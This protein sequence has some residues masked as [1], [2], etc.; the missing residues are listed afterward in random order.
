MEL[1]IRMLRNFVFGL[2]IGYILGGI[3][4]SCQAHAQT[5]TVREVT[6]QAGRRHN[7]EPRLLRAIIQVESGGNPLA[8]GGVGEVGLM[9][10]NPRSFKHVSF[11]ISTNVETGAAYLAVLRIKCPY[12]SGYTYVVCYNKGLRPRDRN[13]ASTRYYVRV[14]EAYSHGQ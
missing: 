6:E 1:L 7:I 4:H 11:N 10:L 13:P 9:Q 8:V 12:K 2:L 14:M 3:F 5:L